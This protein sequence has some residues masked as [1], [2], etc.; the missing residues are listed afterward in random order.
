MKKILF[1]IVILLSTNNLYAAANYSISDVML[2]RNNN[3]VTTTCLNTQG[4]YFEIGSDS[5]R[6]V[7]LRVHGF[8]AEIPL[9]N[10][11]K[12]TLYK[13]WKLQWGMAVDRAQKITW[14]G[15][16]EWTQWLK[17]IAFEK[18]LALIVNWQNKTLYVNKL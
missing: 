18:N 8:Q 7:P 17:K 11:L 1:F 9:Y 13:G 14:I 4:F 12:N 2:D 10:A 6:Y 15:K 3:T 5:G 16:E